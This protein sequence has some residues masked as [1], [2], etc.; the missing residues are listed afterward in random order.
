MPARPPL[1]RR[2]RPGEVTLETLAAVLRLSPQSTRVRA[3]RQ[4]WPRR[5][6][7][8]KGKIAYFVVAGLPAYV[9]EALANPPAAIEPEAFATAAEIARAMDVTEWTVRKRACR[10]EWPSERPGRQSAGLPGPGRPPL[11]FPLAGLP[12]H[13]R[14]AVLD[15]RSPDP[16]EPCAQCERRVPG[17]LLCWCS[18]CERSVCAQCLDGEYCGPC[19]RELKARRRYSR[20]PRKAAL[21]L[22]ANRAAK[23]EGVPA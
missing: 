16:D 13:V 6:P 19:R 3:W 20:R 12:R 14:I 18:R 1:Q 4:G 10:E 21:A 7:P 11:Q 2:P 8:R 23:G 9:R 5:E 17:N 22:A 15:R